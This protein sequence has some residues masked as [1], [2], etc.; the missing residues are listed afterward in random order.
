M[1][2][3]SSLARSSASRPAGASES[4]T[5]RRSRGLTRLKT[6]PRRAS[7][8]VSEA[9]N[10]LDTCSACAAAPTLAPCTPCR[11][12]SA[13]S[14][15]YCGPL[16]PM[17]RPWCSRTASMRVEM[18]RRSCTSA[19]K[20]VSAPSSISASRDTV[21][22]S[23]YALV[24]RDGL[25]PLARGRRRTL[26]IDISGIA[27]ELRLDRNVQAVVHGVVELPE[28]D[29]AGELHDLRWAQMLLHALQEFVRHCGRIFR[30]CAHVVEADAFEL[31]LRLH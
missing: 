8:P 31:V 15:L 29:H 6:R 2:R 14:R 5:P 10:A 30:G 1:A 9:T 12:A 11:C 4:R 20:R 16:I 22:G 19:R 17:R 25:T 21:S 24:G 18:V 7:L 13:I 23:A 3:I 28:A 27:Q 26:E